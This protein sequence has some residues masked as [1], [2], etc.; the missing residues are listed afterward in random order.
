MLFY[1]DDYYY[2]VIL[3]YKRF[4][5]ICAILFVTYNKLESHKIFIKNQIQ[6]KRKKYI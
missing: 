5:K 6:S 2:D 1:I 3:L 4:T